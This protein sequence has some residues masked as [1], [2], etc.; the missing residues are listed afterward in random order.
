[1]SRTND[2]A[3]TPVQPSLAD[4]MARYLDRQTRAH[5]AG[6]GAAETAEVVPFEATPVQPVDPRVAWDGAVAALHLFHQG[7]ETDSLRVPAEWPALVS[8]Y[9][10]VVA[11]AC[12]VGNFPQ[13]VRNFYPLLHETDLTGLRPTA[14]RPLPAPGLVASADEQAAKGEFPGVL[15]ALGLLRLAREFDRAAELVE[16]Q[17]AKVPSTWRAAWAN[18]EAALTWHRSQAEEALAL[19]QAQKES[20]PVLFNCG[21]AALFLGR[22]AEGRA[23]L[24]RAVD[25]VAEDNPWHHLGR[26]YLAL[27]EMRGA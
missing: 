12:C 23:A 27:A 15:L 4:L 14:A 1:M 5:T 7:A 6:L 10:P 22:P 3:G 9:E 17:R 16:R 11:L 19:W 24:V 21:M 26:L 8:A 2:P 13:L 25:Q 20:A 18:E